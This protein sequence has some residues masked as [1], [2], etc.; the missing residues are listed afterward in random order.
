ML[1]GRFGDRQVSMLFDTGAAVSKVHK[2]MVAQGDKMLGVL[3]PPIRVSVANNTPL[4][5]DGV[6]E[7]RIQVGGKDEV[8]TFLVAPDARWNIILGCDFLRAKR[9]VVDV[10]EGTIHVKDTVDTPVNRRTHSP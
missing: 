9:C 8:H 1:Q 5:I 3:L 7:A 2:S 6:I 10:Q 4:R